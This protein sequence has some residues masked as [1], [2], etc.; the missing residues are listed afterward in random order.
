MDYQDWMEGQANQ[1]LDEKM[2]YQVFLDLEVWYKGI[3]QCF[4]AN[5]YNLLRH[6]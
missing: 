1:D 6:S 5:T 4:T 3:F 2:D